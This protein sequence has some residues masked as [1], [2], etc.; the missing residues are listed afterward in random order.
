MTVRLLADVYDAAE[1]IVEVI[2]RED[3]G[4]V[5]GEIRH[6]AKEVGE[7]FFFVS[8]GIGLELFLPSTGS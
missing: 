6:V 7:K 2:I 1:E 3:F 4:V 5:L 8:T